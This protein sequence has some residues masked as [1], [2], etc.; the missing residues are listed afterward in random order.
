MIRT[1]LRKILIRNPTRANY[2]FVMK[3]WRGLFDL[4]LSSAVLETKRFTQNLVPLELAAPPGERLLVLAPHPDDDVFGAGGV[5]LKAIKLGKMVHVVYV[6]NGDPTKGGQIRSEAERVCARLGASHTFLECQPRNI[7]LDDSAV[8]EVLSK[9]ICSFKPDTI[10]TT[11]LLDDHDDHRRVNHLL[12]NILSRAD[13]KSQL[14][15]KTE[16]WWIQTYTTVLPNVVIDISSVENEK[17]E[18]IRM[19][20]TVSGER[21]WEQYVMGLNA[22]NCRYISKKEKIFAEVFFVI[23]LE[24]FFVLSDMYFQNPPQKLYYSEHY[25]AG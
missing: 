17:R 19:W 10:F 18:L 8:N 5:L 13:V 12:A 24:E 4:S 11:F 9:E 22:F 20:R 15:P 7:P 6:T 14:H 2:K 25:A 16:V 23:P 3:D 21:D 1:L